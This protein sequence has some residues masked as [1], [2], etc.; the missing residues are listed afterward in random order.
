MFI[1]LEQIKLV[2]YHPDGSREWIPGENKLGEDRLKKIYLGPSDRHLSRKEI[3]EWIS[4]EN[5]LKEIYLSSSDRHLS[6][7]ETDDL[8]FER[9][10][11]DICRPFLGEFSETLYIFFEGD[12]RDHSVPFVRVIREQ[13]KSEI[14]T[15]VDTIKQEKSTYLSWRKKYLCVILR[16]GSE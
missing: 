15:T 10:I 3:M 12:T 14:K 5:R 13:L 1:T 16:G 4:G 2:T 6:R 11:L 9:I 7:K 8:L